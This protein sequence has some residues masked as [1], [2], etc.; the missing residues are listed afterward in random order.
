[1]KEVIYSIFYFPLP[2]FWFLLIAMFLVNVKRRM[3]I[4]KIIILMFYISLT[5][6]FAN[7][8]E[9]PLTRGDNFDYDNEKYSAVLVPTAGIYKDVNFSWH[10]SSNSVLRAKLG[11]KMAKKYNLP[12]IISGGKIELSGKSEAETV[13][14]IINYNNVIL[15]T[16]SRNSYQT[17]KNMTDVY[18]KNKLNKELSIL[19]VTSAKHSLRMS[20]AL[21]K[22]GFKVKKYIF[23]NKYIINFNS[24][25]PDARTINI[26]NASLYEYIGIIFYF[27]KGYI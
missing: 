4:F 2:I 20:L 24:F 3:T 22:K 21:E 26:N 12:L 10:P 6:L 15:E 14:K 1:M 13:E 11:E 19:L 25:L 17:S 9:Y 27:L 16:Y 7:I 8:I 23:N 5:P 18:N